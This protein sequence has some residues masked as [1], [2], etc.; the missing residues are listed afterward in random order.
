MLSTVVKIITV[1]AAHFSRHVIISGSAKPGRARLR[2][3]PLPQFCE[4]I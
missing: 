1:S 4:A 3:V 2:S